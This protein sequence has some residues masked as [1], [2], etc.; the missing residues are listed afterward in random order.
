LIIKNKF[1]LYRKILQKGK[2]MDWNVKQVLVDFIKVIFEKGD[3][4]I[5]HG[6][7]NKDTSIFEAVNN[8]SGGSSTYRVNTTAK[9]FLYF[10]ELKGDTKK[11]D[12]TS[13]LKKTFE[14]QNIIP[15]KRHVILN[16]KPLSKQLMF[17]KILEE[18]SVRYQ[19]NVDN[20]RTIEWI[21]QMK[22]LL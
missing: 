1:F 6:V 12:I 22:S 16:T 21:K 14:A 20:E 5:V 17:D 15:K 4:E 13:F 2:K 18:D 11:I 3:T 19:I 10:K 9:Y 8:C 7:K